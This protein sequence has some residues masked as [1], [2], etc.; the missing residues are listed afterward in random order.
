[1][2]RILSRAG[3]REQIKGSVESREF[4]VKKFNVPKILT[5][6]LKFMFEISRSFLLFYI[7]FVYTVNC[8]VLSAELMM[9]RYE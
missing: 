7:I 8:V 2:S 5:L 4:D 9:Y 6:R 3:L 1:M